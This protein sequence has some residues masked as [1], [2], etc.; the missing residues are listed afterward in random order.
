ML[1][2]SPIWLIPQPVKAQIIFEPIKQE[3]N[4]QPDNPQT[5]YQSEAVPLPTEIPRKFSVKKVVKSISANQ[6]TETSGR[7]SSQDCNELSRQAGIAET[8]IPFAVNIF[9][10]ESGCR[11]TAVNKSSKA[12]GICQSLP[13]SKMA[14]AG[15]DY[16]TNPLTQI[17]WCNSYAISRYGSWQ[18]AW[19]FWQTHRWW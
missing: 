8:D 11:P 13:A 17:K 18:N 19:N 3:V 9:T 1:L 2:V 12:T 16:L 15:T 4:V 14:T 6:E 7:S 5:E 10:K